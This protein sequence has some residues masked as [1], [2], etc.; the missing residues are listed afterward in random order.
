LNV[1]LQNKS[2]YQKLIA[3]LDELGFKVTSENEIIPTEK[4]FGGIFKTATLE[5]K[6]TTHI[7]AMIT[8]KEEVE[9]KD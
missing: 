8:G 7:K 3:Q 6:L 9:D 4:V 5:E 2:D 1:I